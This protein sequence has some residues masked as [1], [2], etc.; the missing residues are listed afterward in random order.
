MYP[1]FEVADISAKRLLQNWLWLCPPDLRLV[2]V[3]AF[4]DLFL[5]DSEGA[6]LR[7]AISGG[8]LERIS[9]SLEKFKESAQG[10]EKRK[11]WFF[12]DFEISMTEQGLRPPRGQC[13]GY[14]MPIVFKETNGA[15]TNVYIADLHEYVS[16]LG[17]LHFQMRNVS[18]GG[19][20]RL[21]IGPNR[22]QCG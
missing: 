2:V 13:L 16:F 18:D 20:V 7:L 19:N 9:E 3:N 17:D 8:Q 15:A 11:V 4:G 5:E 10:F 14:K 12:E 22:E 1:Y 21:V 6:I